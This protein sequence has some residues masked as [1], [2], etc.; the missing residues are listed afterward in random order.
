VTAKE[1]LNLSTK[2][3]EDMKAWVAEASKDDGL[4]VSD[5]AMLNS[6]MK[7]IE[8]VTLKEAETKPETAT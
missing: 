2:L 5:L 8:R 1:F 3:F 4:S 6:S 7:I